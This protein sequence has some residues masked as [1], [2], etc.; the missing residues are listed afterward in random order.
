MKFLYREL[1]PLP[2]AFYE[3]ELGT[4]SRPDRNGWCK[5]NCPF[6]T[7]KSRT[8]FSVNVNSGSF[9]CFGCG[10]HGGDVIAFAMQRD[11]LNFKEACCYLGCWVEGGE[12]SKV[13]AKVQ[14]RCLV[15]DF[16]ID[17]FE[18]SASVED[19]PTTEGERLRRFYHDARDRLIDL[20]RGGAE[21]FEGEEETQWKILT[22]SWELL[23]M[24]TFDGQR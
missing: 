20:R 4:L 24:E 23:Q 11:G 18:Y 17:G 14:V 8:S 2:K 1:R 7:S 16:A 3:R 5:G 13:Q 6:H 12:R 19:E 10:V 9:H 21:T 15:M 22:D